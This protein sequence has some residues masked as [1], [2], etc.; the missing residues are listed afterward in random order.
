MIR[1]ASGVAVVKLTKMARLVQ[2][3]IGVGASRLDD[4]KDGG[5]TLRGVAK[6]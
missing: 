6:P 1:T 2:H 4:G 5:E 3:K